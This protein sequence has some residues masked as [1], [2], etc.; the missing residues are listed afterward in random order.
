MRPATDAA[1]V[2]RRSVR[3]AC[4]PTAAFAP[5]RRLGGARGWY[6]AQFLW[7]LRGFL[8]QLAGGSGLRSGRR[9]PEWLVPGDTVGFWRVEAIEPDR[10]LQL[11]AEMR[12]PGRAW[13]R[14]DVE[15]AGP[16]T[17]VRQTAVF[18]PH[19][20]GGYAYWYMLFP[21]HRMVFAGLLAAIAERARLEADGAGEALVD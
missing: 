19:G 10:M 2:D 18:H 4:S 15:P 11:R 20:A 16:H 8:D 17:V 5:I 14:F 3:V 12:L 1:L 9:D 21:L 7:R 6:F 13:L